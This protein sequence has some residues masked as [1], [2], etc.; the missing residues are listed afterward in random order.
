MEGRRSIMSSTRR[1]LVRRALLGL[2]RGGALGA[3]A[4]TEN[5]DLQEL[6]Q[7]TK[8]TSSEQVV[9]ARVELPV[10]TVLDHVA[11]QE[12]KIGERK[13]RSSKRKHP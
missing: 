10:A 2:G 1:E 12:K 5:K 3:L 11:A 9:T 4:Q 7:A 8:I 13:Q 6:T